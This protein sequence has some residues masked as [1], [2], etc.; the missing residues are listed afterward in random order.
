MTHT[1]MQDLYNKSQTAFAKFSNGLNK[2]RLDDHKALTSLV[3]TEGVLA[4]LETAPSLEEYTPNQW[5][6]FHALPL[7]LAT[8]ARMEHKAAMMNLELDKW[9]QLLAEK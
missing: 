5:P 6:Q 2:V 7:H 4:I 3:Q 9:K 8:K 1:E